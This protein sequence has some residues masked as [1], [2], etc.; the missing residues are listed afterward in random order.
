MPALLVCALVA[1]AATAAKFSFKRTDTQLS[2]QPLDI[3]IADLDGRR[4][5]DIVVADETNGAVQIFINKGKGTFKAPVSK[6]ACTQAREVVVGKLNRGSAL[7]LLVD[8]GGGDYGAVT[9]LGKGRG[10]FAAAKKSGLFGV[11]GNLDLGRVNTPGG[12]VDVAYDGFG[13]NGPV[14]C[15]ATGNGNGTFHLGNYCAQDPGNLFYQPIDGGIEVADISGDAKAEV[16]SYSSQPSG[17]NASFFQ[18]KLSDW[19]QSGISPYPS[20]RRTGASYGRAI[21]AADLDRDGDR[22]IVTSHYDGKIGVFKW[23]SKGIPPSATAKLYKAGTNLNDMALGDF[24][25]DRKLDAASISSVPIKPSLPFNGSLQI[26]VGKGNGTFTT[27]AKRFDNGRFGGLEQLAVG[28]L[29]RDG[30]DDVASVE[31]QTSSLSIQLSK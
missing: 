13:F 8:C 27:P 3:A 5:P 20:H 10:R 1:P 19:P 17:I 24:N 21:Q 15:V 14:L 2:F 30:R 6:P 28:D 31:Y 25:G 18:W 4:G 22:D 11:Q 9:L 7:D 16:M 23:G 12:G 29:N 26:N